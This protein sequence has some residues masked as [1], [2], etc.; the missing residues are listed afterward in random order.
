M[1]KARVL[2]VYP[3][4][5]NIIGEAIDLCEGDLTLHSLPCHVAIFSNDG[6]LEA[7]TSGVTISAD[8]NKYPVTKIVEVDVPDLTAAEA[9]ALKQVGRPYSLLSCGE[10]EI[11]ATIGEEIDLPQK[12]TDCSQLACDYIRSAGRKIF[13]DEPAAW[14]RPSDLLDKLQ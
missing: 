11:Y 14:I 5:D 2:F 1:D 6:L 3:T 7:L 12:G 9:W 13:D 4:P 8:V 10:S